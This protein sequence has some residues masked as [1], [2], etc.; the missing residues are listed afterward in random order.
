MSKSKTKN[1]RQHASELAGR[2]APHVES[3]RDKAAPYVAD[4]RDKAA[5]YVAEA[6]SKAAPL[7]ADARDRINHEVVPVIT[8]A[9]AAA[10]EATEDVREEA[11]RRGLA[12]AA[13]LR[14]DVE[15]PHESHRLRKALVVLG[16]GG[17]IAFV[18]RK[19]TSRQPSTSW[20]SSYTPPPS[21]A[22]SSTPV[23]DETPTATAG[24]HAATAGTAGSAGA[25]KTQDEGAA[26]P[27]EA[28]ADAAESPHRPTTPDNPVEEID[29][30]R[31]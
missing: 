15:P 28:V 5:P 6:R 30:K 2:L 23:R 8:A 14:G 16:L 12:T 24:A 19:L 9:L 20:Q 10:N 13:A 25:E 3:A 18:V 17:A 27:D 1:V 7:V 31:D 4:A 29:L 11:K 26:G 22:A 21:P